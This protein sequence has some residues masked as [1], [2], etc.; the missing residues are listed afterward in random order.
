[1]V[2]WLDVETTRNEKRTDGKQ[3]T[4]KQD[5]RAREGGK[6]KRRKEVEEE[7]GGGR[8]GG[9]GGGVERKDC[10]RPGSRDR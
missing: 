3:E 10:E 4:G 2:R 9:G 5:E 1:M 8:S 6:E 7:G